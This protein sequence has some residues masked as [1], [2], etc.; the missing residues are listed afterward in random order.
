MIELG[1]TATN[2]VAPEG[3]FDEIGWALERKMLDARQI[4]QSQLHKE[5]FSKSDAFLGVDLLFDAIR[6]SAGE[7]LPGEDP[8]EKQPWNGFYSRSHYEPFI[9]VAGTK[10]RFHWINE[11]FEETGWHQKYDESQSYYS[12]RSNGAADDSLL[13]L[14]SKLFL[15]ERTLPGVWMFGPPLSWPACDDI[16]LQGY[17]APGEVKELAD[18]IDH[19]EFLV[20]QQDDELFPLFA[21]RVRRS[22]AS[23]QG[24]VT[25]HGAL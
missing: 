3:Y 1:W 18:R 4:S 24:L 14:I 16:A 22:V 8:F 13:A 11:L 19:L 9:Q 10:S 21:D 5:F 7:E 17:L 20:R 6:H 12:F 2:L 25:M 15:A 23:G